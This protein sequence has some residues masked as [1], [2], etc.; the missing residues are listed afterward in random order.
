MSDEREAE[1]P[2]AQGDLM[3]TPSPEEKVLW[4]G[5]PDLWVLA[6]TAFHTRSAAIYFTLLTVI[7]V[8]IGNLGAAAFVAVFGLV[9]IAILFAA[10]WLTRKNTLYI[11][12]D[13]RVIMRV[14]MAVD[15]RINLP[16][17]KVGAAHLVD[18]GKGFGD[19]A[20]EPLGS[21][22]LGYLLL[23]PHARPF[24]YAR[25]QPMLRALPD[26]AAV[27]EKLA[28]ATSHFEAIERGEVAK[29]DPDQGSKPAGMAGA[30]A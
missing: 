26:V 25:P 12:T 28:S 8:T 5:R 18:R 1:F 21:H 22:V 16:L 13:V 11:L 27:A 23:W 14:G 10:A 30:T 19:I 17:K 29:I 6:R 9:A 3:G 2:P 15:K 4:R 7:A 24:R 20:L